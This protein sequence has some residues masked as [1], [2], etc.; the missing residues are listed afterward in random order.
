[1]ARISTR[2]SP[3]KLKPGSAALPGVKKPSQKAKTSVRLPQRS[4]AVSG[5]ED[6]TPTPIAAAQK[7]KPKV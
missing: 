1:M 7:K 2:I 6:E 3:A 5:V 4:E